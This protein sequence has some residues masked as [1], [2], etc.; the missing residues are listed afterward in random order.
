MIPCQNQAATRTAL[1]WRRDARRSQTQF[2][3]EASAPRTYRSAEMSGFYSNW[4]LQ[5]AQGW[6]LKA[7]EFENGGKKSYRKSLF[8]IRRFREVTCL[9]SLE[10]QSLVWSV[11]SF[12]CISSFCFKAAHY[13]WSGNGPLMTATI[14]IHFLVLLS[15]RALL[16]SIQVLVYELLL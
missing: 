8:W 7:T 16:Q 1:S 15:T 11:F 13:L 6:W 9:L 2:D 14:F 4:N 3:T 5:I 12:T 10:V